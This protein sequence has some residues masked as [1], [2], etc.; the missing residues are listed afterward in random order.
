MYYFRFQSL[1]V[2]W[3]SFWLL[4]VFVCST[5]TDHRSF[6]GVP[7]G[8]VYWSQIVEGRTRG[9]AAI[10]HIPFGGVPGRGRGLTPYRLGAYLVGG[11][12]ST[13]PTDCLG[14]YPGGGGLWLTLDKYYNISISYE[15]IYLPRWAFFII[16]K[17]LNGNLWIE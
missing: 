9:G 1:H 8:G 17:V 12:A 10:D 7:R 15:Y 5:P 2:Q 4:T 6:R 11:G 13:D 3:L 16:L 14:A